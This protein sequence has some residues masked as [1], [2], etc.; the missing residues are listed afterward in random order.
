MTNDRLT[1]RDLIAALSKLPPETELSVNAETKDDI[2]WAL[3]MPDGSDLFYWTANV[4]PPDF[5]SE[6]KSEDAR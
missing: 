2:E 1:V 5:A 4:T 3:T 6:P